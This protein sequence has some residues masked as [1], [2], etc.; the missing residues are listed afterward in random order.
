MIVKP[1]EVRRGQGSM[2]SGILCLLTKIH[3]HDC[4]SVV[5]IQN[6]ISHTTNVETQ[7]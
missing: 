3:I 7:F 2:E 1:F 5:S 4:R 6:L